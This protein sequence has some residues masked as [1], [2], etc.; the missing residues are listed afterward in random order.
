MTA[1]VLGMSGV[2][3]PEDK[4]RVT[5]WINELFSHDGQMPSIQIGIHNDGVIAL[6]SGTGGI[7]YGA[8]VISGTGMIS[9]GYDKQGHTLRAGGWGYVHIYIDINNIH[10]PLLGDRGSG[11][12]IGQDIAYAAVAAHVRKDVT[13][14]TW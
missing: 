6:S 9:L 13:L 12:A 8:V 10:S 3:R 7:L 1:I 4:E 11:F 14:V 5:S 2:D